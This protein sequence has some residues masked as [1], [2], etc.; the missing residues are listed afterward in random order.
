MTVERAAD[1]HFEEASKGLAARTRDM[2]K[3][4]LVTSIYPVIGQM[5][6]RWHAEGTGNFP[7]VVDRDFLLRPLNGT[8][9]SSV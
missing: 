4:R 8:Q 7:E 6:L 1:L 5:R 2:W 9:T 3:S